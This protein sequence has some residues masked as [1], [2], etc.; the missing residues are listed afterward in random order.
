MLEVHDAHLQII[1]DQLNN[2]D[3]WRTQIVAE[4]SI[5]AR[6]AVK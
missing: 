2:Q 3:D 5:P 4:A 6:R 1:L